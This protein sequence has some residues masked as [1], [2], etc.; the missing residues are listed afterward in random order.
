MLTAIPSPLAVARR[1]PS[2]PRSPPAVQVPV[3]KLRAVVGKVVHVSGPLLAVAEG[4]QPAGQPANPY[5]LPLGET[6]H[7]VHAEMQLQHRWVS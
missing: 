2:R 1:N 3:A 7:I 4:E 6:Y 5:N